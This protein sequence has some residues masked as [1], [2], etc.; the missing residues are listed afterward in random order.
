M[1][2]AA[3]ARRAPATA[4]APTPPHPITATLWPRRTLPVLRAAPSPAITPQPRR[5]TA[6]GR[7]DGSTLVHCPACTSV[8]STNAPVPRAGDSSRP[9]SKVIFWAA[10]W[11]SKQYHGSPREHARQVPH[12]ARQLS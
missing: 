11:V 7:A 2:V 4:A 6:A 10:L 12:T 3:P 5:P 8:F 1:I 9:S